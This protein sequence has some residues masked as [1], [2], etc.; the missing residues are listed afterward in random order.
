[1]RSRTGIAGCGR[2]GAPML[3]AL[4]ATGLPARGYDVVPMDTPH[5][6]DDIAVFSEDLD[7]LITVVRDI[8]QTDAVLFGDQNLA[9]IPTLIRIIICSTLSP[10]YVRDLRARI[11]SHIALIDAPMS[12]AQ[13]AAE[14]ARLSFMIGGDAADIDGAMP[15]FAAMGKHFHRMGDYGSGMQ[16]KVL[17]NLLAASNTAMTRLVLDWADDAGLDISALLDLI[18][19]SS[20]QNWLAS[21]FNSIEFARDGYTEDNTIAILVKDIASALDAAPEGADTTLPQTIQT[22]IRN[23][24]PRLK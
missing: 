14:E 19:T 11:P 6:T 22:Q 10:R 12:G 17:N 9:A 2:M 3:A 23:L 1:M 16:A 21:G 15:L 5:I 18:H 13:I 7:T 24:K 8:D 4:R 20:G